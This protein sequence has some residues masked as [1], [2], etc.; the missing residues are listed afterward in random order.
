MHGAANAP[1]IIPLGVRPAGSSVSSMLFGA[2]EAADSPAEPVPPKAAATRGRLNTVDL[3][4]EQSS[5]LTAVEGLL[6][7]MMS[8][9]RFVREVLCEIIL[10]DIEILSARYMRKMRKSFSKMHWDDE[11]EGAEVDIL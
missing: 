10:R 7:D 4:P 5:W 6:V 1:P 3:T 9:S 2:V 11:G 8:V